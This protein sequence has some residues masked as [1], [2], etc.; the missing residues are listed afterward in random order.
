MV[1]RSGRGG[2]GRERYPDEEEERDERDDR[3]ERDEEEDEG[4]GVDAAEAGSQPSWVQWLQIAASAAAVTAIAVLTL[5]MALG[6]VRL[7][8]FMAYA[9]SASMLIGVLLLLII[10]IRR[11]LPRFEPGLWRY[12]FL[13]IAIP[14][15]FFYYMFF[16]WLF[17]AQFAQLLIRVMTAAMTRFP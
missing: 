2:M 15:G 8:R 10:L 9:L 7:G 14:M 6:T 12:A 4:S 5:E 1:T 17:F 3:D 16:V 11:L 13:F